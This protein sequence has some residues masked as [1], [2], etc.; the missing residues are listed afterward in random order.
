MHTNLSRAPER[1]ELA[2]TGVPGLDDVLGG[3]LAPRR[4]FLV[5]GVPGSGK[6]TLAMSFL[7]EAARRGEPVLCVTLSESREELESVAA[8]HGWSLEGVTVREI[9]PQPKEL[10]PEEQY[11]MFHPSEVE[12]ADT[13]KSIAAEADRLR[14]TRVVLDSLSELRLLASSPLRYR[15]QILAMKQYFAGSGATLLMLDDRIVA[16]RDIHVQSLAHGVIQLEQLQ[17]QYGSDR[18]RLRVAKYR[19]QAYR[20]GYHDYVIRRGGLEVFPRLVA[21]EHRTV[22]TRRII[23]S[24]LPELDNVLGGGIA[25][26]TSTLLLGGSGTGKSCLTAQIVAS[27]AAAGQPGAMFVFDESVGMLLSRSDGLG[28]P[29]R[30]EVDAGRVTLQQVDP[31][32]LSPGELVHSIRCAVDERGARVIVIDSLNGYLQSMPEESFLITQ[33][34]ELLSFL[35]QRGVATLLVGTQQGLIGPLQ[36]PIDASYLSDCV[37]LLRYFEA[38]GEVRQAISVIKKRDGS[39]E[40]TIREFRFGAGGISI[41]EPL[42]EMRGVLTGVPHIESGG[43]RQTSSE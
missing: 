3:G 2:S 10:D 1:T 40:R 39:H 28:I 12:L 17:P 18:R 37:I 22:P 36:S 21:A 33:L 7:R 24:G 32:E 23:S 19:G 27:A 31:A 20:A 25:C 8:S 5:E 38:C 41:R 14:P 16:E 11:T 15:R 30:K 43:E 29:L 42:T 6:T 9:I 35:G 4:V 13:M 26:G 34:H